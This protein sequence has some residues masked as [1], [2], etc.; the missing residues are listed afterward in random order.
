MIKIFKKYTHKLCTLSTELSTIAVELLLNTL[1]NPTIACYF[2]I[3]ESKNSDA[4]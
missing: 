3:F 1:I 4:M 2:F